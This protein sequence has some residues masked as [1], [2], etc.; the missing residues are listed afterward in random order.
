M[1]AISAAR[2][3]DGRDIH[4]MNDATRETA[5]SAG[6]HA[7][8]GARSQLALAIGSIGVV[9]GDIGTSPLYAFRV[10]VKAAVGDGPV[11]DAAVLGVLSLILWSLCFSVTCKYVLFLLRPANNSEGGTLSLMT[12]PA[13]RL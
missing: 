9:Y 2:F 12:R 5:A 10:A 11:T 3:N 1:G 6:G 8:G 4:S 7:A 13:P